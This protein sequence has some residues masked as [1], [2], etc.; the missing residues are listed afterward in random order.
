MRT[1]ETLGQYP[2]SPCIGICRIG[3]DGCCEGCLRTL[4]EIARWGE[5]T[6]AERGEVYAALAGRRVCNGPQG[7]E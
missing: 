6:A 2:E 1:A 3:D 4:D 7:W 5:M